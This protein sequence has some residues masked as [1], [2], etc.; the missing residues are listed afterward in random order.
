MMFPDRPSAE[1]QATPLAVAVLTRHAHQGVEFAARL[2]YGPLDSWRPL[3]GTRGRPMCAAACQRLFLP[4]ESKERRRSASPGGCSEWRQTFGVEGSLRKCRLA[5]TV[6]LVI[7][8]L[9]SRR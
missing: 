2:V 3:P 7:A 5:T 4:Q 8:P 9:A 1:L 6:P